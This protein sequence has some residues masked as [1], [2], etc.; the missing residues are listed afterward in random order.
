MK[1]HIL[2]IIMTLVFTVFIDSRESIAT[3]IAENTEN[4]E[5]TE[6]TIDY[7]NFE[8]KLS[9]SDR[10]I[11][12]EI[13]ENKTIIEKDM[14]LKE[15]ADWALL[16]RKEVVEYFSGIED[17]YSV[18]VF[19]N[20]H[21]FLQ[22]AHDYRFLGNMFSFVLTI[23]LLCLIGILIY[24]FRQRNVG[25]KSF[26]WIYWII[27]ISLNVVGLFV[28]VDRGNSFLEEYEYVSF[29]N[30]VISESEDNEY[31]FQKQIDEINNKLDML[32]ENKE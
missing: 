21:A 28:A 12:R 5:I 20:E 19:D 7:S 11:W 9:P 4:T 8:G 6:S 29:K 1:R 32:L 18:R 27:P 2:L 14:T 3:E 13:M 15:K 31:S 23:T 17:A 24:E 26:A 16:S 22:A 30:S 25:F 10:E